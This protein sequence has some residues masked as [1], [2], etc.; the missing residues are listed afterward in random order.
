MQINEG[1]AD[2]HTND[3]DYCDVSDGPPKPR[4]PQIRGRL[5]IL[6]LKAHLLHLETEQ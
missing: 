1:N 3:N 4:P 6:D 5:V 2:A